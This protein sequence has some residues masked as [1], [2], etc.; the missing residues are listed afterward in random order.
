M[1]E[2]RI[3]SIDPPH[4]FGPKG[5][6]A[7]KKIVGARLPA[8][9]TLYHYTGAAGLE[10][11]VGKGCMYATS[12]RYLNDSLEMEY[13]LDLADEV[14]QHRVKTASQNEGTRNAISFLRKALAAADQ[15]GTYVISFSARGDQLSQWRGY[16][17]SGPGFAIGVSTQSLRPF[18][19]A[20]G[21]TPMPC[22]YDETDHRALLESVLDDAIDRIRTELPG[23]NE[24]EM[25]RRL[26]NIASDFYA[27]FITIAP[28]LKHP[29]FR[30]EEEWRFASSQIAEDDPRIQF[31]AGH[32]TLIPYYPFQFTDGESKATVTDL[33]V[34]P[35]HIPTLALASAQAFAQRGRIPVQ[36]VRASSVPYREV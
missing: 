36:M 3:T 5:N 10:G 12:I 14:L 1:S 32:H 34:G 17:S 33:V 2:T 30:E 21:F 16:C 31:R 27:H 24:R 22:I 7:F 20:L 25:S 11:I 35:S 19:R 9:D 28:A 15:T 4:L 23:D 6:L 8:P 29:S 18:T 13:P 26:M